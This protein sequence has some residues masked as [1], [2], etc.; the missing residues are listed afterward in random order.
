MP[1]AVIEGDQQ[2]SNDAERI[3]ATGAPAIQINTGK[4]CHLD[5]HM[6]GH[7]LET[8]D[9]AAGLGAVHRECRQSRLPRR[10]R[11]RR[12]AQGRGALGDR[13]RGQAAQISRHVRGR[14]SHA[15]QQVRPAA[16][17]RF[18]RRRVPRQCAAG[19]SAS[20]DA[21]RLGQDRRRP[22]RLRTPGSKRA[23]ARR[24]ADMARADR[25]WRRAAPLDARLRQRACACACAAPC[26]A[27]AFGP[28]PTASRARFAPQ[29]LRA[30]RRRGRAD[31][32]RGRRRRAFLACAC[33]AS[34]RRSRASTRSTSTRS[35]ARRRRRLRDSTRRAGGPATT[36]IGAD[37][38]ICEDCLA[39]LFDPA[40]RFYRYP[41]V[42]CTHCGPRYTLTRALP[43][44]RAQTSMAPF[45]MCEDCAR[46]YADPANRRFHA[47]PIACPRCGPKLNVEIEAIAACIARG[48]NR[49][50]EGARRLPP[51]LRRA[52]RGDGRGAAPPQGARGQALRR[53]GRQC[54]ERGGCSP[55]SAKPK[56]ALLRIARAADRPRP[57]P[58]RPRPQ[59]RA[60]S[61]RR[62]PDAR[63][64]AAAL[65]GVARA[66]GRAGFRRL[67]RCA[68]AISRSSPPAP[69]SAASRWSPTTR[70]RAGVSAAIADLVVDARPRDRRARRRFGDARARRRARLS[71]PRARLRA[72]ADR[73]RRRRPERHRRRRAISRTP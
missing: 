60:E 25:R 11:S 39:E 14:R 73:P 67:A 46:D 5:A 31:R 47:E 23:A 62:R 69:I 2:T 40:S 50:A 44:D 29:R 7:A 16:A 6:V 10:V 22:G 59:R 63:L 61:A 58:R 48:R 21:G 1:V 68:A 26:R 36:R 32:S 54:G 71:A 64:Y 30:Q 51:R 4:G 9:A 66:G 27:S 65:A 42:N 12:G 41:F 18:R 72:R 28:S 70:T 53:D 34:R 56:L 19:Q 45:P 20:A 55:S 8:L 37:A 35:A 33:A 24:A 15:A 43:Y 49:R 52:Q 38:A 13:G 17:S 57:Q 3:R